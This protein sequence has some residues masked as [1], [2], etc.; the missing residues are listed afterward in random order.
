METANLPDFVDAK[1]M[2]QGSMRHRSTSQELMLGFVA[3]VLLRWHRVS[4]I[5]S[6]LEVGRG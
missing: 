4:R 5:K 2:L 6:G 3:L 1:L